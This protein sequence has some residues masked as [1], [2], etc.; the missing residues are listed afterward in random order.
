MKVYLNAVSFSKIN[1]PVQGAPKRWMEQHGLENFYE[2]TNPPGEEVRF[3]VGG[4]EEIELT[5]FQK[6]LPAGVEITYSGV[7]THSPLERDG[8]GRAMFGQLEV[9]RNWEPVPEMRTVLVKYSLHPD[10]EDEEENVFLEGLAAVFNK[11]I[12]IFGSNEVIRP[13]AFARALKEKQDVRALLNHDPSLI[14]GRTKAKTLQLRE[15][16][17]G[18]FS[19]IKLPRTS[20][21]RDIAESVGRGDV[22]GMSFQFMVRKQNITPETSKTKRL[23]EILDVDLFDVSV[24][25]FPAFP[26]TKVGLKSDEAGE[27]VLDKEFRQMRQRLAELSI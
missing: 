11:T 20:V 18:L 16:E 14:L 8:D 9:R 27:Q 25:T 10:D 26:Q 21:G 17:K 1:W 22:D 3:R 6:S 5:E 4:V 23:R 24:V 15:N 13:G 19:R 2:V 7:A 12:P